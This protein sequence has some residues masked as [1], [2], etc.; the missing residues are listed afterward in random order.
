MVRSMLDGLLLGHPLV[1]HRS[2]TGPSS[3][4]T[5]SLFKL[6]ELLVI[7]VTPTLCQSL[8]LHIIYSTLFFRPG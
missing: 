8:F 1:D 3:P 6:Y 5:V 4:E 2:R 7:L